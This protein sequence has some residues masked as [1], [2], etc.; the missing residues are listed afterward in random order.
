[1]A[2][3]YY[4]QN[5]DSEQWYKVDTAYSPPHFHRSVEIIYGLEGSKL[6]YINGEKYQIQPNDVLFVPPYAVHSYPPETEP[7]KQI[8]LTVFAEYCPL[9]EKLCSKGVPDKALLRDENQEFLHLIMQLEK[10][11]N[12]VLFSGLANHILGLYVQQVNFLPVS[13]DKNQSLTV[14]IA[15]YIDE[16][17]TEPL[18]LKTL[19]NKFGYSPNHFSTLFK[20]NFTMTLTAYINYVRVQKSTELL[21]TNQISAVYFLCGFK[22]PQQYFLNFKKY[23][24]CTPKEYLTRNGN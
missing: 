1:M 8:A 23:Y 10:A 16:H 4:E 17:F 21:K 6:A 20:K 18:D 22:N 14:D 24:G 13:K 2:N 9:F 5:R 11:K 7:S 3:E 19:A 12:E 15:K